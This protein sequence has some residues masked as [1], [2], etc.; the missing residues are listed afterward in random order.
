MGII[1][2]K[3][4]EKFLEYCLIFVKLKSLKNGKLVAVT[5]VNIH[6]LTTKHILPES[7]KCFITDAGEVHVSWV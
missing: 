5:G 1:S 7:V 4:L 6:S 2:G 3:I